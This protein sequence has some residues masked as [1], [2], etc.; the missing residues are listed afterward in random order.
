MDQ[1]HQIQHRLEHF[2]RTQLRHIPPQQQREAVRNFARSVPGRLTLEQRHS[3]RFI[4]LDCLS[5][6]LEGIPVQDALDIYF[7]NFLPGPAELEPLRSQV[8]NF[9]FDGLAGLSEAR[10]ISDAMARFLESVNVDVSSLDVDIRECLLHEVMWH[11]PCSP[12]RALSLSLW[13]DHLSGNVAGIQECIDNASL[14]IDSHYFSN[15]REN[16]IRGDEA[17]DVPRPRS[18]LFSNVR[19]FFNRLGE[20]DPFDEEDSFDEENSFDEE[21]PFDEEASI[22]EESSVDK[23]ASFDEETPSDDSSTTDDMSIY[24]IEDW[25]SDLVEVVTAVVRTGVILLMML[26][27][28]GKVD[29][30]A[31]GVASHGLRTHD[32]SRWPRLELPDSIPSEQVPIITEKFS[33]VQERVQQRIQTMFLVEPYISSQEDLLLSGEDLFNGAASRYVRAECRALLARTI[34]TCQTSRMRQITIPPPMRSEPMNLIARPHDFE[35]PCPIC[36]EK[37]DIHPPTVTYRCC[38]RGFHPSCLFQWFSEKSRDFEPI[39]CPWCRAEI[40]EE[41][42]GELLLHLI[43]EEEIGRIGYGQTIKKH[44]PKRPQWAANV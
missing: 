14:P 35:D 22:D 13:E 37:S 12:H 8:K 31:K 21:T 42:V 30:P 28:M 24:E 38:N 23:E 44:N 41:F 18:P 1:I 2:M 4:F 40:D 10:D 25:A 32:M 36:L 43:T 20:D 7:F 5:R 16:D 6:S 27:K 17:A 26:E 29:D 33:R 39:S 34:A 9:V 15:F 19:H 11:L 3:L